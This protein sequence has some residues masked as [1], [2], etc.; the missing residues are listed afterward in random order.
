MKSDDE[1]TAK[2]LILYQ[3]KIAIEGSWYDGIEKISK[4]YGIILENKII[5]TKSKWKKYVKTKIMQKVINESNEKKMMMTKL[6]HQKTQ[7]FS[8]QPYIK[9][10]NIN[11]IRDLIRVKLEMLDIGKNQGQENRKCYGCKNSDETTEHITACSEVQKILKTTTT[12]KVPWNDEMMSDKSHLKKIY[13]L[14]QKYIKCREERQ[15]NEQVMES[16]NEREET[17]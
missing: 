15:T 1:R 13:N 17:L 14:V 16:S 4:E 12:E 3:K 10:T 2:R 9:E 5:E 6:R 7:E 8:M 11:R